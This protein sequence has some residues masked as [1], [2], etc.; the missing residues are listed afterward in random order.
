LT[1]N[2]DVSVA[3]VSVAGVNV[4][5]IPAGGVTRLSATS[6]VKFVRAIVMVDV[7][8]APGAIGSVVGDAEIVNVP[9]AETVMVIVAVCV[10]DPP[11]P[12][13]VIG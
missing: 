1:C 2:E 7:A 10:T 3:P 11:T 9:A 12:C 6:V 4:P 5:V 13:T 8:F